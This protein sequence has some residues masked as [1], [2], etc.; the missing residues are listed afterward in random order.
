MRVDFDRGDLLQVTYR[1]NGFETR[2]RSA[3]LTT[4]GGVVTN[5]HERSIEVFDGFDRYVF[6][7]RGDVY[8]VTDDELWVVGQDAE[9]TG[10]IG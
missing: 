4:V 3:E 7:Q 1:H 10:C 6:D 5:V 2:D 9:I 8:D